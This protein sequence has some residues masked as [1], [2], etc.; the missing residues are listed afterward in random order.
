MCTSCIKEDVVTV[1]GAYVEW[2][3]AVHNANAGGRTYPIITRLPLGGQQV[4]NQDPLITSASGTIT[5]RVNLV[6]AHRST[7]TEFS[8]SA[9]T[10]EDLPAGHVAAVEGVH[11]T[12]TGRVTIPA[13]SSF[14]EAEITL[15][16]DEN[17]SGA[18]FLLLEL[19]GAGDVQIMQNKKRI[20]LSIA[21]MNAE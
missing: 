6:A 13:N 9:V 14:G 2:D 17:G 1:E 16:N 8:F 3:A 18:T 20:G 12:T 10:G 4:N 19:Q 21:Q 7:D 5:L 11:Y 15:L